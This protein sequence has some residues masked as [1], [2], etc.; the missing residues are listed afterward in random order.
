MKARER[1][2]AGG[3]SGKKK[4]RP[5][6]GDRR[7][8]TQTITKKCHQRENSLGDPLHSGPRQGENE[9]SSRL[10]KKE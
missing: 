7:V 9:T 10:T 5:K 3:H 8:S 4:N 6:C 2:T 1:E